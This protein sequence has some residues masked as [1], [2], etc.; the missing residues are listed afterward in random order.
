MSS[1]IDS[2][3]SVSIQSN[4]YKNDKNS[5]NRRP[6]NS[7]LSNDNLELDEETPSNTVESVERTMRV[8]E[9]FREKIQEIYRKKQ[10]EI[11]EETA[12]L[13][14]EPNSK[15]HL[16]DEMESEKKTKKDLM[17]GVEKCNTVSYCH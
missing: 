17:D 16:D 4:I 7:S 12:E 15:E 14:G 3:A 13:Y 11:A 6:Y 9:S 10:K 1:K 2:N 5:V 8:V